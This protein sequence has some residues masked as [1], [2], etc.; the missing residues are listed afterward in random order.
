MKVKYN[1]EKGVT[2]ISLVVTVVILMLLAGVIIRINEKNEGVLNIAN[3]KK[4]E[5]EILSIEEEIKLSLSEN[6]PKN[7]EELIEALKNYGSIQNSNDPENAILITKKEN[8]TLYVKNLWN[9]N[10]TNAGAKIGDYINYKPET[11]NYIVSKDYSGNSSNVTI[12][13]TNSENI[14]WR[15]FDIDY[16]TGEIKL[17]PTNLANIN[18]SIAGENGYN[19]MVKLLNDI[20]KTLFSNEQKEIKARSI[21]IED[22]E[23]I[24]NNIEELKG[25]EYNSENKYTSVKYPKILTKENKQSAQKDFVTGYESANELTTIQNYYNGQINYVNELYKEILPKGDFWLASRAVQ[26]TTTAKF[27]G[28]MITNNSGYTSINA[29]ELYDSNGN[30]SSIKTYSILPIVTLNE[31]ALITDGD[32]SSGKPFQIK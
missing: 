29:T 7:Y 10:A 19:N 16:N 18:L 21:N 13:L 4:K 31:N 1:N 28:K 5:T 12:S 24:A 26:N 15:V 3:E 30:A 25:N 9:T 22:I 2:L 14:K 27:L 11:A 6:P 20:C 23:N 32:G 8:Y 17:I